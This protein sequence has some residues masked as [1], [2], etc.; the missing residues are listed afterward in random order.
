M[1]PPPN[2]RRRHNRLPVQIPVVLRGTDAAGRDFFDRAEVVSI[3][4]GGGRL[5]ARFLLHV[6]SEVT[7]QLPG[8]ENPKRLRVIWTGEAGDF[9]E[10]MI[11]VEFVEPNESW[12]LESLRARWEA[13][14]F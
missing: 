14:D 9:Y 4:N 3:D 8:E 5:R 7:I 6:G 13:A 11:G 12:N 10:G 1:P 2:D